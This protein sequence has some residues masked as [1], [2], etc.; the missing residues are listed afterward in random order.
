[1]DRL[2]VW[3]PEAQQMLFNIRQVHFDLVRLTL[4]TQGMSRT[5]FANTDSPSPQRSGMYPK[6]F[7]WLPQQGKR[8]TDSVTINAAT[9]LVLALAA[10]TPKNTALVLVTSEER[11]GA[12]FGG[13]VLLVADS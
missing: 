2:R 6:G 11:G 3:T 1:M 8:A 4:P 12:H 5:L 13:A 10:M 9:L 7:P